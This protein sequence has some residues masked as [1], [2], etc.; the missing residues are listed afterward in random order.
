MGCEGNFSRIFG[1]EGE[2]ETGRRTERE[3]VLGGWGRPTDREKLTLPPLTLFFSRSPWRN[4]LDSAVRL[5]SLAGGYAGAC[6]VGWRHGSSRD[7]W[8]RR[9]APALAAGVT[10]LTDSRSRPTAARVRIVPAVAVAARGGPLQLARPGDVGRK[11]RRG[12]GSRR[13]SFG[14]WSTPR[15]SDHGVFRKRCW[16]GTRPAAFAWRRDWTLRPRPRILAV[17]INSTEA[18]NLL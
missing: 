7:G 13:L 6:P 18:G 12:I 4:F 16:T 17:L 11:R 3:A 2:E 1:I 15:E 8:H 14:G 10:A 9:R 5:L